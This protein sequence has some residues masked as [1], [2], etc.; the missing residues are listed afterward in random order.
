MKI[1]SQS[2][3]AIRTVV[4]VGSGPRGLSIL[5]R[6]AAIIIEKEYNECVNIYLIDSLAIGTGRIWRTE[7]P[8]CLIMNTIA[9][10]VS[11][12]SGPYNT[13]EV[14]PGSGPS[15]LEWWKK[16]NPNSSQPISFAPR[17]IYG[18]YM[19]YVLSIIENYLPKN[20]NLIKLKLTVLDLV[21]FKEKYNVICSNDIEISADKVILTTG[22]AV[23]KCEGL[24]ENYFNF[25]SKFKKLNYFKGD[26][27]ADMN[28]DKIREKSNVGIIG[29]GLSFFDVVASLTVGRGGIFYENSD[30]ELRYMP[31]GREPYLFAGSRSG[32]PVLARGVNQKSFDYKYKPIIFT[33]DFAKKI[34]KEGKIEFKKDVFP[35]ILAEINLVYFKTIIKNKFGKNLSNLFQNEVIENNI[36]SSDEII[37]IANTYGLYDIDKIDL[38]KLISPF[39]NE[40]FISSNEFN[41]KLV[42]LVEK[43]ITNA[44][45]GNLNSPINACLDVIRDTRSIIREIV[46]YGGLTPSS[47]KNDFIDWYAPLCSF[48]AAGP[49]LFRLREMI[50]LIK[51][52]YLTMVGPKVK[53]S[54]DHEIGHFVMSS[55]QILSQQFNIESLI[56]ARIP[57]T[58]IQLDESELVKNLIKKGIWTNY[59][60]SDKDHSYVT[61][62]VSVTKSPYY[63]INKLGYADKR[64][65][66]LGI[67]TE[68]TR[69]FMQAGSSRPGFWTDFIEDADHIARDILY[70]SN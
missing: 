5:E 58:A 41:K 2:N 36:I 38:E 62:G 3:G 67:P 32:Y 56:D 55:P 60:N 52:G 8:E 47:H 64:I 69:W 57:L 10:E 59:I 6:I 46:D 48:L 14:K 44:K 17:A 19:K 18:Y 45:K 39:N 13:G 24:Q 28:L 22:H 11:A 34:R 33:P 23:N 43:D 9:G 12:F 4:I 1:N 20:I 50:A 15:L 63:P 25:S 21:D 31:S 35:Y 54:C 53:I 30:E 66:V 29:L 42:N 65:H 16:N 27:V 26:S 68:H 7:Q 61:G 51:S 70:G 40:I 37:R 49:P